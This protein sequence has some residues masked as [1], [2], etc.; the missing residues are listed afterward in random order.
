MEE[1]KEK[2]GRPEDGSDTGKKMKTVQCMQGSWALKTG[3]SLAYRSF[4][5]TAITS[6]NVEA[7]SAPAACTCH[8]PGLLLPRR[9]G[10]GKVLGG[11][12]EADPRCHV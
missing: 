7:R 6:R 9:P 3:A 10:G 2:E 4:Q 12:G 11:G 1:S 5:A 8:L